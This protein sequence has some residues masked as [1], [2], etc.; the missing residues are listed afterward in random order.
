MTTL[1]ARPYP[2]ARLGD[3]PEVATAAAAG[4]LSGLHA[5]YR[6]AAEALQSKKVAIEDMRLRRRASIGAEAL[7]VWRE[8]LD[9]GRQLCS[10]RT[11]A[12]EAGGTRGMESVGSAASASVIDACTQD[13]ANFT[14]GSAFGENSTP[15]RPARGWSDAVHFPRRVRCAI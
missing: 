6:E 12:V 15:W 10:A 5:L 2:V 3:A 8:R 4:D 14:L 7:A 1:Y 9:M 13:C 11:V